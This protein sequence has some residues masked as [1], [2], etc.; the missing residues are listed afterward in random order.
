MFFDSKNGPDDDFW[1]LDE[2]V[3]SKR[4]VSSAAHKQFSSKATSAVEIEVEQDT[5]KTT[6]VFTD[7]PINKSVAANPTSKNEDNGT[8]TRFIPPHSDSAFAKKFVIAEYT[9]KNP[10]IKSVKIYADKPGEELFVSSNL[11]IRERRALLHRKATEAPRVTYY[12]FSPRYSQMSRAQLNWY[13]WWRENTR[14]GNFLKTDESYLILYAY[15]LASSGEDE[16]KNV[17]LNMLCA[18]LTQY[19]EKDINIVFRMMIRDLI[20]D[21]CLLHGLS[22]PIAQ[23]KEQDRGLLTNAFLPEFFLDFSEETRAHTVDFGLSSLSMYDYRRSK[24]CTPENEALFQKVMSEALSALISDDAAFRAITAFTSGMYGCVTAERRPF[25]RMVNVVNRNVKFEISYYQLSNVQSTITDAVRYAENKLREHLGIK[26]KLHIMSVNPQIK[27]ALDAFFAQNYPAQPVID[28]RRKTAIAPEAEV[29]EYDHFYD[30]PK[31]E[32]SPEKAIEIERDSWSTTKILT[33]AFSDSTD[34]A[35]NVVIESLTQPPIPIP[36][37]EKTP[38]PKESVDFMETASP[39]NNS[40]G[41]FNQ[42]YAA[43]GEIAEFIN[44]CKSQ[45]P[46]EQRKFASSRS[47]SID[48]IA[49]RINEC[50]ADLFG[51]ILLEDMGGSYLIIED[52]KDQL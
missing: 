21:F 41:L 26:N 39:E 22:A 8:I 46:Y 31:V 40:D 52:Y 4:R 44:L 16:D 3:P 14:N 12:S 43:L 33:E 38:V 47:L 5:Q 48:E 18:L 15:E 32:I 2:Y 27:N 11:F 25:A 9:P 34:T 23:L 1:N 42:I 19:T 37:L 28:R 51:D 6:T 36:E 24:Y 49:D 50:A 20:C 29:H 10:L 13:L 45:S 17:A 7:S 30:V 35:D